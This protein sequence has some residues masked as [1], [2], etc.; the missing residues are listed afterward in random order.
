MKSQQNNDKKLTSYLTK[1]TTSFKYV[2][3]H[4]LLTHGV[5]RTMHIP[6]RV[7]LQTANLVAINGR[8]TLHTEGIY[9]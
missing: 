5:H 4:F 8:E 3:K 2:A 1:S 6:H 9:G 7:R